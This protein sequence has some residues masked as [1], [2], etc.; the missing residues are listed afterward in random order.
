MLNSDTVVIEVI[1]VNLLLH[2]VSR[3]NELK[4]SLHAWF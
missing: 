2:G 1:I 4:R 3:A